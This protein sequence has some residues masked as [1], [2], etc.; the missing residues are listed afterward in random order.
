M[1]TNAPVPLWCRGVLL[2]L[3]LFL[4]AQ[5]PARAADFSCYGE[6]G[7]ALEAGQFGNGDCSGAF[8][9]V[10]H[11]GDFGPESRKLHAYDM[12]YR[13]IPHEGGVA[14]GGRRLILLNAQG[15]Y[16]GVY[17]VA[18]YAHEPVRADGG[19]I[20]YETDPKWGNTVDLSSGI[21][22]AQIWIAGEVDGFGR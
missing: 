3:L 7:P 15:A 10:R 19:R 13:T 20:V 5:F 4:A 1:T 8:V 21:P 14:H 9:A 12:I 11:I 6:I 17:A 22:P 18:L 2:F 16:L